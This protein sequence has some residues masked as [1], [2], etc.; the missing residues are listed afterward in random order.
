MA[1]GIGAAANEV[2]AKHFS[3]HFIFSSRSFILSN[4]VHDKSN[5][6]L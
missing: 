5:S 6:N 3:A 2:V 1:I 4:D